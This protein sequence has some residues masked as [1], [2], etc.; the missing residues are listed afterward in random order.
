MQEI[1]VV[2]RSNGEQIVGMLHRPRGRA[3]CPAAL[4]LHGFTGSKQETHRLFV[5]AAR[6][7]AARGIASLRI[8][9]RGSG[10]SAGSFE[11]MCVTSEV[12]DA[13]AALRWLRRQP[14]IDP[15]RIAL[16]GLSLG[17]LVSSLTQAGD[18][19]LK[20]LVLWNPVVQPVKLR[21]LLIHPAQEKALRRTGFADLGGWQVCRKFCRELATI[22]SLPQLCRTRCAVR[23]IQ[24]DQDKAVP[25]AAANATYAAMRKA[26]REVDLQMLPGVDHCF[27][28]IPAM[29]EVI[30]L[31]SEWLLLHLAQR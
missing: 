26:G 25:P 29:D 27:S 2:F 24:G 4:F 28:N 21:D 31:T 13:R 17:G 5:H 18:R 10:D 3:T 19:K 6:D 12:A 23:I 11:Q 14:G 30:R 15:N 8:D 22:R 7:L 9:F 20:A 1:P 16:V